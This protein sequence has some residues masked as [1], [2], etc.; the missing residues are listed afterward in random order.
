MA[1]SNGTGSTAIVAI[2]VILVIAIGAYFVFFANAGDGNGD[3]MN[4]EIPIPTL[5]P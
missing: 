1:T 5:V 3:D 4:N 2:F